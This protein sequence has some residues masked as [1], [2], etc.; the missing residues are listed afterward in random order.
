MFRKLLS[1]S[2]DVAPLIARLISR[3]SSFPTAPST[4]WAGSEA[5]ASGAPSDG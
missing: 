2:D 4:R 3:S 5:T 1:T